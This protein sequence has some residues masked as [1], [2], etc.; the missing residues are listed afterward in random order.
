MCLAGKDHLLLLADLS[1]NTDRRPALAIGDTQADLRVPQ[2]LRE[3]LRYLRPQLALGKT[4]SRDGFVEKGNL[5]LAVLI[6]GGDKIELRLT[7]HLSGDLVTGS[8]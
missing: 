5:D 2:I 8:Y 3:V 6:D 4:F 1:V 7:E